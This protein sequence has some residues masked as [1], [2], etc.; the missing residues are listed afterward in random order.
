MVSFLVAELAHVETPNVTFSNLVELE[1]QVHVEGDEYYWELPEY[2]QFGGI[3]DSPE[4]MYHEAVDYTEAWAQKV[5]M[6][7][8]DNYQRYKGFYG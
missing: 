7:M 2:R 8:W 1:F 3:M 4:K 5:E 6:E